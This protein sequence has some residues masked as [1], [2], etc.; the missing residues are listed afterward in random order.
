MDEEIDAIERNETWEL[1]YL[2]PKKQV[3]G[4]KLVYKIKCNADGKIDKHKVRLVVKGYK[5]QFGRDY[6]ETYA[7]IA[8]LKTVHVVIAIAAQHKWNVFQMD[9]KSAFLNGVLKEEVYVDQPPGYEVLSEEGK[10]YK[11]KRA[12][13]GL[14]QAQRAWYSRIDSYLLSNGFNKS[15]GEPTLYIKATDGKILIVVLYVDDLIFTK[16]DDCLIADFKQAMKDEFEMTNLG[17]L[18]Y[19]LGIEVKQMDDGI[20]ISQEKYAHYILE[21]FRT[22]NNKAAPTPTVVG[23]KLS[24]EDCS[25]SVDPTMFKSL[26][27]SLMY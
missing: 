16:D 7:P 18:R 20:F 4:V 25:S 11:L 14:K 21:R 2:P 5:Q 8:R 23:L 24:K 13:Y 15:D 9:V 22:L 19:F 6:D 3:I 26:V 1:T 10:V 27:G 12:L 17:I